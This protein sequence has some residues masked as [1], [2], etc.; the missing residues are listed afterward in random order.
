VC[1]CGGGGG[2]AH[3]DFISGSLNRRFALL[4][5]L[6]QPHNLRQAGISANVRCLNQQRTFCLVD[7]APDYLCEYECAREC[8]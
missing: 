8:T 6:H 7:C 3:G 4:C 2:Y 1:V 5:L